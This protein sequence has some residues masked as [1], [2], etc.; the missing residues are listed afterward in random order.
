V[1]LQRFMKNNEI[2]PERKA[3]FIH[4]LVLALDKITLS[5]NELENRILALEKEQFGGNN[6][7][8]SE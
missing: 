7:H 3:E 6:K 5:L 1:V 2:P 8:R 4:A